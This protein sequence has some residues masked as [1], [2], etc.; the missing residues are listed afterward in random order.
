MAVGILCCVGPRG[1]KGKVVVAAVINFPCPS[2][3]SWRAPTRYSPIGSLPHL[4]RDLRATQQ[5]M[6]ITLFPPYRSTMAKQDFNEYEE[7][8]RANIAERDALLRKLVLDAADAGLG[9]KPAKSSVNASKPQK[10]KVV[11]KRDKQEL[12]PRR[13]S[14]RIAGIEADSEKA[15]RKA[16]EEYEAVQE[17]AR[18]KRQRIAGDHQLGDI[19]VAGQSW[20]QSESFFDGIIKRGA[21]PYERTFGETEVKATSDKQLRAL[22]E[23]M[24]SLEL[25]D[26]FEP[27]SKDARSSVMIHTKIR[28]GSKSSPSASILSLSTLN[29]A[30]PL[31]SLA[32]NLETLAYSMPRKH[33]TIDSMAHQ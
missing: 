7:Q 15:K 2:R 21:A 8:R 9:P 20:P 24:S 14:S 13:T 26:G 31:S 22:R 30:N 1:G 23:Q 10:K 17:A 32:T 19:V 4:P 5:Y 33:R 28:Q 25:Y 29:R 16:E 3:D 18:I 12:V 27:N 6:R 11:A